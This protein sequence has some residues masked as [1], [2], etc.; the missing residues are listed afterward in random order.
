MFILSP[1][2]VAVCV[3]CAETLPT[4]AGPANRPAF[5]NECVF[6]I[7][8]NSVPYEFQNN[9]T[10]LFTGFPKSAHSVLMQAAE[11]LALAHDTAAFSNSLESV[12][13]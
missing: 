11:G 10:V 5:V 13:L 8:E 3:S 9:Y 4:F 7:I 6:A 1:S 2:V 12:E